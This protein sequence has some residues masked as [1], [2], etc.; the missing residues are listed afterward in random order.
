MTI[1]LTEAPVLRYFVREQFN[2]ASSKQILA[3]MKAKGLQGGRN[4][5]SKSGAPS[6]DADTLRRLSRR[7]PLFGLILKWREVNKIDSTYV[8][9][10]LQR[11]DK[12]TDNRIHPSFRHAPSTMRLS[13]HDPNIQ[14]VPGSDDE[15]SYAARFRKCVVAADDCLLVEAD[16]AAIEAVLTGHY[17]DDP[18]FMRIARWAH[19]YALAMTNGEDVSMD[20]SDDDLATFL[21][22]Y[23]RKVKGTKDYA[24]MKRAVHLCVSGDHEALTP[25]GWVR[26]DELKPG[27]VVAQ[28]NDGGTLQYVKSTLLKMKCTDK[29]MYNLNGAALQLFATK[30]HELPLKMDET[31]K[32][33]HHPVEALPKSGRIPVNGILEGLSCTESW[34]DWIALACAVQA[35]GCIPKGWKNHAVFQLKKDRKI[36]RLVGI[37]RRLKIPYKATP[38]CG[39]GVRIHFGYTDRSWITDAKDFNLSNLLSLSQVARKRFLEE[40][41][42]WDGCIQEKHDRA[43]KCVHR[44]RVYLS[45]NRWNIDAVQTIAAVSGVG[46]TLVRKPPLKKNHKPLWVLSLNKRRFA[47]A[48][49]IRVTKRKA[50]SHVY[51]VTVPSGKWLVRFRGAVAVSMNTHYGGTPMMMHKAHPE[52]FPTV[53]IAEATQRRYFELVPK[54]KQ[55]QKDVRTRAAAHHYLGGRDHPY[56]YKHWFWDVVSWDPRKRMETAGSDWNRVVAYYPQSTAA[57]VLYDATLRL[58]DPES[59]HY[60][61]DLFHGKT[62]I[63]ALIHDSIL[64]EVPKQHL[65]RYLEACLGS[66]GE[67]LPWANDLTIGVDVQVGRDWG[68]MKPLRKT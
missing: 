62:P 60:V 13:S 11:I 27:A 1:E 40:V 4:P 2:P 28:W 25:E 51:C 67:P 24:A 14:N 58:T 7:D 19:T 55:W 9:P 52:L 64:A 49:S 59:P 35:D 12:E 43:G 10:N 50:A 18:N 23:K 15:A 53:A 48:S 17:M 65:D 5:K 22:D 44:R 33:H 21:T 30:G 16:Y 63:R 3:Y 45:T 41:L 20:M 68:S 6:T 57:G 29:Q 46:T 37:L 54:L 8:M 32:I 31:G 34:S 56:R 39:A 36:K 42:H 47:R 61:G 38:L 26:L 66:M